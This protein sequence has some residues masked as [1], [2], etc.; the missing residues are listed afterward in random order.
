MSDPCDLF[1]RTVDE[2]RSRSQSNDSYE[3]LR[4]SGLLRQLLM[5]DNPLVHQ[6]NRIYRI[7]LDFVMS[8]F[9]V[10][11]E[12]PS[13]TFW[14]VTDGLDPSTAAPFRR[15]RT[16][17]KTLDKFLATVV[18]R[19]N[20]TNFTIHDIIAFDANVMGGINAG[21]PRNDNEKVLAQLNSIYIGGIQASLQQ[22]R[23]IAR[24]VIRVGSELLRVQQV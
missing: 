9:S 14:S 17:T 16:V 19:Y 7:R 22:L 10:P 15:G 20:G 21:A 4:S 8:D 18:N 12:D 23:A 6:V 2:L 24:V 13:L 5:D 11:S 1:V 3:V